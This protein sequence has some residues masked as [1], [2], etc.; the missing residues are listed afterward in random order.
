MKK[1]IYIIFKS[2]ITYIYTYIQE[3]ILVKFLTLKLFKY[4]LL[5]VDNLF[6]NICQYI[7]IYI[8]IILYIK[9]SFI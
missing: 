1:L 7:N 6:C 4:V 8:Y 3:Y 5:C 9:L 2:N